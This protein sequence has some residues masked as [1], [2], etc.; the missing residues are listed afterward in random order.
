MKLHLSAPGVHVGGGLVLLRPLLEAAADQLGHVQ[1]D[2]RADAELLALAPGAELVA[3]TAVA[4]LAAAARIARRAEA[5]DRLLLFNS[6]PPPHRSAAHTVVF[7]QA[8][9]LAGLTEAVHYPPRLRARIAFERAWLRA[10]RANADRWLVQTPTMAAALAA[11]LPGA[12]IEPMP[13]RAPEPVER[14]D[15]GA[16]F[17]YPA[18]G[19]AHKNHAR[20]VEAW[21]LLAAEGFRPPLALTLDPAATAEL[22]A[23]AGRG[24]LTIDA[25]GTIGR[26]RLRAELARSAALIF[27]SLAETFGLPLLEAAEAGLPILA[28]E[29]DFVRDVCVPAETFDPVSPRSIADAVRRFLSSPRAPVQPLS[30]KAF[31][32]VL[33]RKPAGG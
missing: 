15:R 21:A 22:I 9:Y 5:G 6:L 32:D 17:I 16:R 24:P 20:L 25:L 27:P 4:R 33:L 31:V 29:R 8:P 14:A 18:S 1:L 28:C 26:D 10:F 7:V 19:E 13:F 11:T 23:R 12:R 30:P 3:P 2:P